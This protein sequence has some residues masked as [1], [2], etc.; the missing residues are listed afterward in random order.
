MQNGCILSKDRDGQ[1]KW[2]P[3]I[4]ISMAILDV[5]AESRSD[6]KE[7]ST[8][9]AQLKKYAKS[10]PGS[11]Y[12]RDRRDMNTPEAVERS[13]ESHGTE[14]ND[15]HDHLVVNDHRPMNHQNT[16]WPQ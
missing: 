14:K 5:H 11:V 7:I 9:V 2:I 4:T 3:L 8:R 13:P 10:L 1:E 16:L 6:L 12:V 15:H